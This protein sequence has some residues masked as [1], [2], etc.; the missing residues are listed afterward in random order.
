MSYPKYDVLYPKVRQALSQKRFEHVIR[1]GEYAVHL[2]ELNDYDTEKAR[3]G[4]FI[5]D[6]A[7]ERSDKDF[8][9]EIDKKKLDPDL[10]N[11]DS[12]IWHGIVGA[13]FIRD[14]LRI[15]DEELLNAVRRHTTGDVQMTTLDK[16][17]FMADFLE[18]G[19]NFSD[20]DV[21]RQV[22]DD[23]LDA[24]VAWQLQ[25]SLSRLVRNHRAIY[26]KS[27]LAYNHWVGGK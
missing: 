26:P 10:K 18:L 19:R 3:I 7:K 6:Y 5:H 27:L 13:E 11:W 24:G 22:T 8:L 25:F 2:A 12:S 16:I 4:G 21:A 15:D 14:E 20:T 17:V 23:S 1:A 9:N